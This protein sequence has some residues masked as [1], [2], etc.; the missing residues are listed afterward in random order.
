M[1]PSA[2]A[3]VESPAAGKQATSTSTTPARSCPRAAAPG[4]PGADRRAGGPSR[5]RAQQAPTSAAGG[6]VRRAEPDHDGG[7]LPLLMRHEIQVLRAAGHSHEDVAT[8]TGVS[9][10]TVYRVTGEDPVRHVDDAA[11]RGT[12]G[13]GRPA[14]AALFHAFV[15]EVLATEPGLMSLEILRRARLKGYAGGKSAL[16]DLIAGLRP[17]KIREVVRFEGLPGEFSQHDFGHVDVRFVDGTQRRVHF[18]ATRLKYSRWVQVTLVPN[19]QTETVVRTLVDH[20]AVLEGI[21]LVA[22]FDRPK[23]IVLKW[24]KDG[25]VTEWNPTF[26]QVVLD[27][28][29]GVELCWPARGNQKGAVE[30]LVGWVKGSFFKPRRF[31]DDEDLLQQLAEWHLEVNTQRPS[32]ATGV[33]PAVRLAEERPRL[34]PLKVSPAELL[35]RI[36]LSVGPTAYVLHDTHLYSMPPDAMGLPATLFLGRDRARI[37]AGRF[38]ATHPRLTTPRAKSTLPEHRAQ[39]VA[40]AAGKRGKRYLKREHLLEL[41]TPALDYIT[42]LV[43]RRPLAWVHEVDRLHE[44]L[45]TSGAHRLCLAF[46]E[47]V[48]RHTIGLEYIERYLGDPGLGGLTPVQQELPL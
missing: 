46:A 44:Y 34:R 40:Y 2:A 32:R 48:A 13:I 4:R 5:A 25:Q 17:P 11:E 24:T 16:Y 37:V 3:Q 21:P 30:N 1:R 22:V 14:K 31:I 20:F 36:P 12:R 28:G 29:L 41:G 38:E 27:L 19:E 18:F 9:V 10:R 15:T 45:Q 23:T 26:A 6:Q 33:I 43:H 8:R 7:M 39:A 35:L 42:E 47:A